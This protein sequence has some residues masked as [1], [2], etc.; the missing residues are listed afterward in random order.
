MGYAIAAAFASEGAAVELVSGP[1]A[2]SLH[3]PAVNI[4]KVISAEEM[5][6]SASALFPEMDIVVFVAAVA[7]YRPEHQLAS[8]LKRNVNTILLNLEPNEDIAGKL[9]RQRSGNQILV[10]F[11]L[12]TENGVTNALKKLADKN[13]DMI[14]LN[15]LNDPGAG[16]DV[17]TN[18]IIIIGKDNNQKKFELKS[19]DDVAKDIIDEIF[20]LMIN[21]SHA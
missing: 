18:K 19:K 2:I 6:L 8:K 17:D 3:D 20:N 5:N 4:H 12:E 9:G 15:R 1:V 13:L 11:A 16:F 7:D 10:G 21:R 14:V